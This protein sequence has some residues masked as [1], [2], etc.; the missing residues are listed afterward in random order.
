VSYILATKYVGTFRF[1]GW[2]ATLLG[3]VMDG[4]YNVLSSF[5]VNNVGLVII[6][7][8][9]IIYACLFPLTYKQQKFS[10]LSQKMNPELKAIQAKYK[11][12]KD[13]ASQM[14]M[15]EEQRELQDKYGISPTGSC[16][17]MAIQLPILFALYRVIY[18]VPAYVTKVKELFTP[19]VDGIMNTDG[20]A[21]TMSN[22]VDTLKIRTMSGLDFTDASKAGNSIIDVLYKLSTSGW[23]TLRETFPSLS[24]TITAT[25]TSV[26]DVNNFLGLNIANSPSDVMKSAISSGKYV[27]ILAALIIPLISG[28]TQALNYKLMPQQSNDKND[29]MVQQMKM[30][31]Y[32]MPLVSI[33]MVY[34]LPIGMGIYWIAGALIRSVQQVLLNKHFDK[35]DLDDIIEKNKEVAAKKKA[36]REAQAAQITAAASISTKNIDTA[37]LSKPEKEEK[38]RQAAE[39]AKNAK[40]GSLTARAN[41]VREF[42]ERNSK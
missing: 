27:M 22:L 21:D 32:T 36:K 12:K 38:L 7:F 18:N 25:Q 35:I 26:T 17:Q 39:L 9:F 37:G 28:L 24:D 3:Y 15:V 29:P 31:N 23:D 20:F 6:I 2:I 11:G 1:I 30:M 34:S 19:A 10:K 14:K 13:Q 8:T 16:L 40:P 41:M 33:I 4:I 42:N 5:G